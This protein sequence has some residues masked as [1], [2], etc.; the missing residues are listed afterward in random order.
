MLESGLES[1][2][3]YSAAYDYLESAVA[4][5]DIKGSLL[6]GNPAFS[7]FNHSVRDSIENLNR[8]ESLLDCPKFRTWLLAAVAAG[9]AETLHQVFYYSARIHVELTIYARPV[10]T[11][12]GKPR[13]IVLTLGEESIEFGERH[14]ARAQESFRTLA[15]RL[16]ALDR[17]KINNDKLIRVLLTDAPFAM[18]LF[19]G[20][21]QIIQANRAAELLFGISAVKLIGQS[22]EQI[23]PCYQQC[24]ACPAI[25]L[26]RKIDAE[27]IKGVTHK[28]KSIPLL[29]SVNTIHDDARGPL[30]I[31]AF[32]DLTERNKAE[33]VIHNLAFYDP[34]TNLPNRR[35]LMDRLHQAMASSTRNQQHGSILFLDLDHFKNLNDTQGHH[36]GD[37]LLVEVTQRLQSC[38]REGDTVARF[39]GDEFVLILEGLSTQQAEAAAQAEFIGEKIRTALGHLFSFNGLEYHC[40]TSIGINLFIDHP[41]TADE[42]LKQAD[43]AMYQAKQAGRNAIRFFDPAMQAVLDV[44]GKMELALR[45]AL[46]KQQFRLHYQI[47]VD[48]ALRPIGAEALLRWKHP[49]MGMVSPAQ[50]IPLAEENGLILP[51][52]LWVLDTACEQ[53]RL[54]QSDPLF[55]ELN[56]AVNISMN[57][58]RHSDFVTQV[59]AAIG[60][61]GIDPNRL[62]LELTESLILNNVEDSISKMQQLKSI[63]VDFSMDDFGT[64]YSSLSYLKRLPLDQIKIDQ[65]F[66]RDISTDANDAAIVQTII[67]M[68]ATLGLKVMAEGVETEVQ[69]KFLEQRG[70]PAF[71]GH[72]FSKAIPIEQ[73]EA[74]LRKGTL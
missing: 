54:W 67:A 48:A 15:E 41:G 10:V 26:H 74:L 72:L 16:K 32:I 73:F 31:E 66:V 52:G 38:V 53:L 37:M 9:H 25:E 4:I 56:I 30:V 62:K 19:N 65:S 70:C 64:G 6:Y 5:F 51:I 50:F 47:Q 24:G 44:R 68:A 49:D 34:L 22:C 63:G 57:Q 11:R 36:V 1:L 7:K 71:Q 21:R 3:G 39:G 61:S 42:L 18:V 33:E 12:D 60:K 20:K 8:K 28:L 43:V 17:D 27:E 23:L 59:K 46:S 45:G 40:T 29:R 55:R 2:L 14:V 69:R 13:G 35:L 58:F